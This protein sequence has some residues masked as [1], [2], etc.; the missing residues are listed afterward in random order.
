MACSVIAERAAL[1]VALA[2]ACSHPPPAAP[3]PAEKP[4]G[5][6][7]DIA[8]T[9]RAS[10]DMDYAY[11]MTIDAD[12]AIDIAIDRNKLGKCESHG[13]LEPAGPH[14]FA[15]TF[16]HD[17]CHRTLGADV[18]TA[19]LEIA[20]FTGDAITVELTAADLSEHRTYQRAPAQ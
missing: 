13:K 2:C 11:A 8:G 14:A 17:N 19:K 10:D 7:A 1:A 5:S 20:S 9:W 12:G 15:V 4:V 6:A 3:K 16:A 18:V